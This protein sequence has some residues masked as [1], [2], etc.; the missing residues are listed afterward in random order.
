VQPPPTAQSLSSLR[1]IPPWLAADVAWLGQADGL[2][3]DEPRSLDLIRQVCFGLNAVGA[4]ERSP[5]LSFSDAHLALLA[6]RRHGP[7][8]RY[9]EA[10]VQTVVS[11][12]DQVT[13]F[14]P[15]VVIH[16]GERTRGELDLVY[17]QAG[18]DN[19]NQWIHLELAIKF[20]IGA[21]DRCDP[22]GWYGP[23]MR[24]TL[25]RK[26]NRLFD[27]QLPLA[28]SDVGSGVLRQL[29]VDAVHS[30][31][32]VLGML[33]HP[34]AAWRDGNRDAPPMIAEN[35]PAG[36]WLRRSDLD[37][38]SLMPEAP[39]T[40]WRV[41]SKP[42]WMAQADSVDENLPGLKDFSEHLTAV[43]HPHPVMAAALVGGVERHRGFVVP[44]GWG[45]SPQ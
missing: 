27:H 28:V 31:A 2:L 16:D 11:M 37:Q 39:E 20:Y 35:H 45:P 41:L 5:T 12:S 10:L 15:N 30:E 22:F 7:L 17:A 6:E 33:F 38:L 42:E 21:G 36:W 43:A 32:L 19:S 23:A 8:G 44:D 13:G 9:F 26:L 14:H 29:T 18:P 40:T 1:T 24:D 3:A 34:L 25:G 4:D